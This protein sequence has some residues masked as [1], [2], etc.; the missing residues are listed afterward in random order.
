MSCTCHLALDNNNSL[1]KISI[2]LENMGDNF[3]QDQ[4]VYPKR[5]SKKTP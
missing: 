3:L 5:I 1:T 2:W 4:G